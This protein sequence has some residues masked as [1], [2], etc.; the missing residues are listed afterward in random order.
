MNFESFGESS[1]KKSSLPAALWAQLGSNQRPPDYECSFFDILFT[2]GNSDY[3]SYIQHLQGI[4][5]VRH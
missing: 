1:H 4:M 5:F 2:L 3:L